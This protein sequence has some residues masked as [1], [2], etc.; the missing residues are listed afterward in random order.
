MKTRKLS[1]CN[2]FFLLFAFLM[3][4]G[5]GLLGYFSFQKSQSALLT[6][7]QANAINIA[8]CASANIDGEL[9]QRIHE[10][11]EKSENYNTLVEQMALFRDNAN[12]EY[13]YT[14]KLS[15][16]KVVYI[17]DAD[18]EEPASIGDECESTPAMLMALQTSASTV[19]EKTVTDEWGTHLS[20]YS[21]V[22]GSSGNIVGAVG[23]DI[24]ADWISEQIGA[25]RNTIILIATASGAVSLLGL[26]FLVRRL[27]GGLQK[28]NDKIKDLN[29]GDG[30]LTKEIDIKSGDELE[31]IAENVNQFIAQIRG[32]VKDVSASA[33]TLKATTVQL[34]DAVSVNT[35]TY[36]LMN[37]Q[38][39]E[40]TASME[41]SSAS[42]QIMEESLS[43][44][45]EYVEEFTK[46]IAE[47]AKKSE[48]AKKHADIALDTASN[49]REAALATMDKLKTR[50]VK[51]NEEI[52]SIKQVQTIAEEVSKIASQ[53]NM[54]SLNASIEAARAGAQGKGFAVVAGQVGKLSQ[55][56]NKAV[57]QINQI[58]E[59]VL[60]A[61]DTLSEVTESINRFINEDVA[62]DYD[63]FAAISEEYGNTTARVESEMG[64]LVEESGGILEKIN[65]SGLQVHTIAEMVRT[66]SESAVQLAT[67]T[68]RLSQSMDVLAENARANSENSENLAGQISKYKY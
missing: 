62:K 55:D 54:L 20:A 53:T 40:I 45:K 59:Q 52:Q 34:D 21:P 48:D 46:N 31:V 8:S 26:Y 63:A 32:L 10:G 29:S 65:E 1:I 41:E 19:D 9:L 15:G 68:S 30:D 28:L 51:T 2:R 12:L 23:V 6:Q 64:K 43:C 22:F 4:A 5:T 58:N 24:S 11:D 66:T 35:Q 25:I 67:S 27:R 37:S 60:S 61:T 16:D 13:I 47:I 57:M 38:I 18:L 39:E 17:V 42:G 7:I 56:I 49:N 44:C 36:T 33:Q 3:L 14:L 50:I